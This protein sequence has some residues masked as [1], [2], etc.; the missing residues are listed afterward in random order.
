[1]S[2]DHSVFVLEKLKIMAA[3]QL[4]ERVEK[5]LK[6]KFY[7]EWLPKI[8]DEVRHNLIMEVVNENDNLELT[9]KIKPTTK[10]GK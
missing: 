2:S 4:E 5:H 6:D 7:N 9:I 1:M 3:L 10:E 8:V